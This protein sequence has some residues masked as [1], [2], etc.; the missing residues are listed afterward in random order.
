MST[1]LVLLGLLRDRS[2]YGYELKHII[3]D[4]MGDWTSIAFGSIYY[5]LAKLSEQGYI[6][7]VATEQ[8][9]NR[10]SRS[11]YDITDAGRV[12][13]MRLL[14]DQWQAVERP[15]YVFDIALFFRDALPRTEALGYLKARVAALEGVLAHLDAHQHEQADGEGLP[16]LAGAVFE[17]SR[18]HFAAELAWTREL[19]RG[20]EAG[21]YD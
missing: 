17:H 4:H 16:A 18:V 7:K 19:L 11:I 10:P 6:A 2:L 20:V 8:E 3:E 9:G 12:E 5:A 14:R 21:L 15:Y 1:R 13:F